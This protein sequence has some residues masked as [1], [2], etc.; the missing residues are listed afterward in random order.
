ML[1]KAIMPFVK[2][3]LNL[4]KDLI[5]PIMQAFNILVPIIAKIIKA[6]QP[7]MDAVMQ[8]IKDLLPV[9]TELLAG[10]MDS[11]APIVELAGV[12]AKILFPMI[13]NI[14]KSL[15]PVLMPIFKIFEGIADY[16][17][18]IQTGDW[19]KVG[20]GLKKIGEGILN[21]L[22]G[23]VEG[24]INLLITAINGILDAIPGVGSDVIP[25]VT[26]PKVKL[27]EGGIVDKPTNALIGEAGPEA[28]IPLNSNKANGVLGNND[29]LVKEFQEMKQILTAILN[30][31]SVITLD[32]NKMGTAM[33]VGSYRIQ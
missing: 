1:V 33:A 23:L 15:M 14:I 9:I 17:V 6:F 24:T 16:I 8:L 28:V 32:G 21:L 19:S 13:V 2:Q 4:A 29:V 10:V 22:I 7:F 20:D 18:G 27:A 12:L 5:P 11:L 30:K 31:N 25:L 3:I 26:F